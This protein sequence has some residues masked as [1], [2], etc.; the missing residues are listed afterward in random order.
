M[1]DGELPQQFAALNI[2]PAGVNVGEAQT[3]TVI[4]HILNQEA[5]ATLTSVTIPGLPGNMSTNAIQLALRE[6]RITKVLRVTNSGTVRVTKNRPTFQEMVHNLQ[7][8]LRE[9]GQYICNNYTY[10]ETNHGP[11][12]HLENVAFSEGGG[13]NF[14]LVKQTVH[15]LKL[16]DAIAK[17]DNRTKP[18]VYELA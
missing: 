4:R 2:A 7:Q 11:P 9:I 12:F 17:V 10:M 8:R 1:A 13:Y 18:A 3:T 5:G 6:L 14:L 16:V 15:E